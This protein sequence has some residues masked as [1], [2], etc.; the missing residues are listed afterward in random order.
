MKIDSSSGCDAG[1][2]EHLPD[3]RT[4]AERIA[5]DSG[6]VVTLDN[7]SLRFRVYSDK[8]LSLKRAALGWVLGR[9][10]ALAGRRKPAPPEQTL[11]LPTGRGGAVTHRDQRHG[12]H[13]WALRDIALSIQAGDRVGIVG[14]NGAGKTTLLKLMARIYT[15]TLGRVSVRGRVAPLMDLGAAFNAELSAHE[16]ILLHG[17]LLGFSRRA[18]L[19]RAQGILEFADV[20]DFA[21]LQLKYFSSGMSARLAFS[22]ATDVDPEILL[23][24]EVFATGDANFRQK[25]AARM[26]SLMGRSGIVVMISH[27]L[28]LVAELCNRVLMLQHGRIVAD[29]PP[30]VVLQRYRRQIRAAQRAAQLGVGDRQPPHHGLQGAQR[31]V[32]PRHT[33]TPAQSEQTMHGAGPR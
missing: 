10:R 24:D 22:I 14:H 15:P 30:Q 2:V 19:G 11:I 16:N 8:S 32:D 1:N 21:D 9:L 31:P 5:R 23:V 26:R 33:S 25:A 20:A 7:V 6:P 4:S 27:D 28:D 13:F 3:A 12:S 17:A 29:G 18:M